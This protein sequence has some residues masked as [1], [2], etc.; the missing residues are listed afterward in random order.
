MQ[1]EEEG[2]TGTAGLARQHH[3][4][5]PS[6]H[7]RGVGEVHGWMVERVEGGGLGRERNVIASTNTARA[8]RSMAARCV[9]ARLQAGP[10]R[11]LRPRLFSL[12]IAAAAAAATA[13]PPPAAPAGL[14]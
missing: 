10:K 2:R 6:I 1:K 9:R 14:V 8:C 11:H 5:H 7:T 12:F 3:P 4:I 13:G